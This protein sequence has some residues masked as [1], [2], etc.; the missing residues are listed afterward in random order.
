MNVEAAY[1][2]WAAIYD[3]N[4]NRTRDL[5]TLVGQ[6]FLLEQQTTFEHV[7]ELGCGTGKN[8][9][10]LAPT[11][12][13]LTSVDLT[14]SMLAVARAKVPASHVQFLQGDLLAP[15]WDAFASPSSVDVVTFSLVLE[16]IEHLDPIFEKVD[17]VLQPG[18]LVYVGE[19]HPFKQYAGTKACFET[20]DGTKQTVT[21]FTHHT[22]DFVAAA[23]ARGWVLARL[24]E[25][26]DNDDRRTVPRILGLLFRKP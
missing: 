5:E 20:D 18:G 1:S 8:S 9:T 15:S 11:T 14:A 3:T 4:T 26:F 23:Q 6:R 24:G 13:R 17:Q 7:L 19:L 25:Y 21:A 10:W 12:R 16:H 22:S 2:Q